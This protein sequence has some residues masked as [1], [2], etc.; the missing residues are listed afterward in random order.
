MCCVVSAVSQVLPRTL[1]AMH[2]LSTVHLTF[3]S[4][5]VLSS[6]SSRVATAFQMR[7]RHVL[8]LLTTSGC[9][10]TPCLQLLRV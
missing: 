10:Q 3:R 6:T 7:P 1:T 2:V 4:S 8:C 9:V 5:Q